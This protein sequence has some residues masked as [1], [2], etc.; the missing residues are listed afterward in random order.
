MKALSWFLFA[1]MALAAPALAQVA[2]DKLIVPGRGIGPWNLDMTVDDLVKA[3]GPMRAIGPPPDQPQFSTAG[4]PNLTDGQDLWGHRW[5]HLVFRITTKQKDDQRINTM[6][7]H[8]EEG[9]YKTREGVGVRSKQEDVEAAFGKPE[10]VT[11]AN[12]NQEHWIYDSLG[13]GFRIRPVSGLVENVI[14]FRPGE[15]R[16]RWKL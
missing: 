5:D 3:I 4:D 14:V 11:K 2:P 1:F 15:A 8:R 13:I 7:T 16:E 9:G 6:N 12:P 10:R